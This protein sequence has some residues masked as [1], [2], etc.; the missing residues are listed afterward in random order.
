MENTTWEMY[1]CE[2][3]NRW[4]SVQGSWSNDCAD[5]KTCY[6]SGCA[7]DHVMQLRN[8]TQDRTQAHNWFRNIAHTEAANAN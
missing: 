8:S 6:F 5:G 7:P 1:E 2:R 4:T 3:G